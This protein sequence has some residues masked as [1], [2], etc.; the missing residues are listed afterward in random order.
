MPLINHSDLSNTHYDIREAGYW[1]GASLDGELNRV[2]DICMGCRLCWNLCPS[3]PALFD[4]LDAQGREKRAAAQQEGRVG[5][6][7]AAADFGELPEGRHAREA[8]PEAEFVGDVT[9]LSQA[10]KWRVVDLCYQCKL[11][12]AVCPYTPAD[13]HDFHLDFPR[14][15]LR[16]A[17][18]RTRRRGQRL[19]DKFLANTDA[20]GRLGTA[21]APLANIANRMGPFRFL[22]DKALGISRH[23][24]LPTFHR[25][26]FTK[27]FKRHARETPDPANPAG[28]AV[29]FATCYTNANDPEVGMAAAEVLAHNE[30][31]VRI[32]SQRCCGAPYLSP[33][34]FDGFR[35]QAMP[36]VEELAR[37][38][39]QGYQIVVT[40]PPT[41][42]MTLRQDYAYLSNGDA[43]LSGKIA[44]VA[45]NTLDIS[46]YLM[47]L[48]T[49]GGLKTDFVKS[50]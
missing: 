31:T 1:D 20:S 25:K 9:E 44:K 14:L 13:E 46:Q 10:E 33:G 35:R 15:M 18:Q 23:R 19:S 39:D 6:G 34:D 40:G 11:C 43:E 30:V 24:E 47:R 36:N 41:C 22:M 5:A 50:L 38:V 49:E 17:A 12:E 2:Y 32:A 26:T 45:A 21:L 16:A 8:S 4:A 37:W 7:S 3:F 42:S 29:I 48:H 28:K 27:R